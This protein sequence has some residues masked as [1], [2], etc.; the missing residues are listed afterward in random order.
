MIIELLK[1]LWMS[2]KLKKLN[3]LL[4]ILLIAALSILPSTHIKGERAIDV[5]R[6]RGY[7]LNE[8]YQPA[9]SI[10]TEINTG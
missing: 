4:I 8:K 2:M 10:I 6:D 9:G 3:S 1:G 5:A 7:K